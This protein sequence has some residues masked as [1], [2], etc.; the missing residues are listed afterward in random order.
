MISPPECAQNS[1]ESPPTTHKLQ[2]LQQSEIIVS[3]KDQTRGKE[4]KKKNPGIKKSKKQVTTLSVHNE[5]HNKL[6]FSGFKDN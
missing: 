4:I 5:L 6:S 3:T 1:L 2:G